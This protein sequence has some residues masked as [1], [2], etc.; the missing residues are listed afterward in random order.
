VQAGMSRSSD[1]P[2]YLYLISHFL[3]RL[4]I[5]MSSGDRIEATFEQIHTLPLYQDIL[6]DLDEEGINS[7]SILARL[8]FR[9]FSS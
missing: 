5:S 7:D 6:L 3:L 9:Y 1:A 8:Y 4:S 2:A